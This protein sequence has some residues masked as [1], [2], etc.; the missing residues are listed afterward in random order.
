ME[1]KTLSDQARLDAFCRDL[2]L[3]LRRLTGREIDINTKYLPILNGSQNSLPEDYSKI[4][5]A[6]HE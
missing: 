1:I 3:A 2:A 6:H 5:G 4:E